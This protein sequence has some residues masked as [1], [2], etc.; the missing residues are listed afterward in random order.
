MEIFRSMFHV[1][2]AVAFFSGVLDW[3]VLILSWFERSL[4]SAQ[5]SGQSFPWPLKLMTSQAV[6][7]TRIRTG[8]YER[9]RGEWV[10][11]F[12]RRITSL[13]LAV[14]AST[15]TATSKKV[16]VITFSLNWP[17]SSLNL[18]RPGLFYTSC[19]PGGGAPLYSPLILRPQK[20]HTFSIM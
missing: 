1:F 2:F 20:L 9:L 10:N 13:L 6:E 8:D 11:R 3:I 12:S 14:W 19:A 15:V 7:G 17:L 5:V 4:H 16:T 18:F